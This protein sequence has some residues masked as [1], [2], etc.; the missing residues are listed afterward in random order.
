MPTSEAATKIDTAKEAKNTATESKEGDEKGKPEIFCRFCGITD[1][2]GTDFEILF[3]KLDLGLRK[4][5]ILLGD[6]DGFLIRVRFDGR[7]DCLGKNGKNEIP[8]DEETVTVE[9]V[10]E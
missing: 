9:E 4:K 8:A 3:L 2:S 10:E 5:R 1:E 6:L 7:L